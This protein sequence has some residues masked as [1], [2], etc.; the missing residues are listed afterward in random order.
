MGKNKSAFF[1]LVISGFCFQHDRVANQQLYSKAKK[2]W[3]KHFFKILFQLLED[4][5]FSFVKN[6]IKKTKKILSPDYSDG[7]ESQGEDEVV[8]ESEDEEEHKRSMRDAVVKII[9]HF[10]RKMKQGE[11]ADR[12][13]NSKRI[14]LKI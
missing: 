7:L 13:Q 5:I 12:L 6:E 10:L 14:S 4:N 3:T 1:F 8:L 2:T 9:L 11:L